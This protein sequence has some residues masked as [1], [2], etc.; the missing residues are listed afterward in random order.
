MKTNIAN[1]MNMVSDEEKKLNQLESNMLNH[2]YT[3]TIKELDG[4][5]TII[6]GNEEEFTSDEDEYKKTIEKISK[7]KKMIYTK[8]NEFKLPNG[9]SIQEALVE[10]NLLRKQLS[11]LNL[12]S[13]YRDSSRRVTEVNNSYFECKKI[14]FDAKTIKNAIENIQEE[15]QK[16]E[17]EI[18]KLNSIEFEIA[19]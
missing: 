19:L 16:I 9:M 8:N 7:I 17:F 12:L 5:E 10:I 1:L 15:I 6:E 2:V 14:N 13:N 4:T 18:S 11:I 3:V